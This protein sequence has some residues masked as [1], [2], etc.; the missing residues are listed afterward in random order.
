AVVDPTTGNIVCRGA[1][2]GAGFIPSAAG[3]V[4]YNIFGSGNISD[5]ALA[6]ITDTARNHSRYTQQHAT[7]NLRGRPFSTWAGPVSIGAGLEYRKEKQTVTSNE[8]SSQ[9]AYPYSNVT[10]FGGKFSVKEAYLDSIIPLAR[11]APFAR[12]LD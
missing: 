9:A 1:L 11:D 10:P 4:P 2:P 3:C 5:E 7:L 8:L 12:S 6:W